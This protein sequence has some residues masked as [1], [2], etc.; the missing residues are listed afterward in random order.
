MCE[1]T[2]ASC[3]PVL[4]AGY[5]ARKWNSSLLPSCPLPHF[6]GYFLAL[7]QLYHTLGS[8][9]YCVGA[10]MLDPLPS[11]SNTILPSLTQE[12]EEHISLYLRDYY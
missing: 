3:V 7:K 6:A 12:L 4:R 8:C 5:G 9:I 2:R 10:L 11:C 1:L